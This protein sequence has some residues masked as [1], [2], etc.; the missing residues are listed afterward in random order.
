MLLV[1]NKF[2]LLEKF[3]FMYI[4]EFV[5]DGGPSITWA[6]A[7]CFETLGFSCKDDLGPMAICHL[8]CGIWKQILMC[9]KIFSKFLFKS[10]ETI[11]SFFLEEPSVISEA[12]TRQVL[13][14][15]S[16]PFLSYIT[17]TYQDANG[18]WQPY[19][20]KKQQLALNICLYFKAFR[21]KYLGAYSN[22]LK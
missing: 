16:K 10:Y 1:S 17:K 20:H 15:F 6:G 2:T 13:F 12:T 5:W 8:N 14:L 19:S 11:Y 22:Y 9:K 21:G 3:N 7:G 4:F 18:L